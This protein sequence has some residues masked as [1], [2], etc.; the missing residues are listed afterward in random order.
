MKDN[1]LTYVLRSRFVKI[2]KNLHVD[3]GDLEFMT[4]PRYTRI[5]EEI[6]E[7]SIKIVSNKRMI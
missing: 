4:V 3:E 6:N 5:W 7:N 1:S 2:M